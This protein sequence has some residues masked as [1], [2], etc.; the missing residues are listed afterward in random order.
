MFFP[1]KK[2]IN[3]HILPKNEGDRVITLHLQ[4][5]EKHSAVGILHT[6]YRA[7]QT[8]PYRRCDAARGLPPSRRVSRRLCPYGSRS[9]LSKRLPFGVRG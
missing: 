9:C 6:R 4:R 2:N 5:F 7:Y 1:K 8:R 3:L